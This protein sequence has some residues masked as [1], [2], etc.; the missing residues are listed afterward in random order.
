MIDRSVA[1]TYG[2]ISSLP[3]LPV[4]RVV[5]DGNVPCY[6]IDGGYDDVLR[7]DLLFDAG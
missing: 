4:S 6:F 1:P 3:M 7:V 5:A 2:E